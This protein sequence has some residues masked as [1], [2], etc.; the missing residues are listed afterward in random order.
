MT[1]PC[2][3]RL[4]TGSQFSIGAFVNYTG[5][6]G[7]APFVGNM[8]EVAYWDVG[9]TPAQ[10]IE[11]YNAGTPQSLTLHS[12]AADLVSWW[13]MGDPPGDST[14]SAEPTAR[15]R[16]AVGNNALTPINMEGSDIVL[17]VP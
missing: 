8:D 13:R 14:N 11:L 5:I 10:C 2:P 1:T 3:D 16:D 17:D 7:A 6:F 4:G 9:F 15:V 12:A